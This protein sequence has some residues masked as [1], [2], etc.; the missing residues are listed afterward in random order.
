MSEAPLYFENPATAVER[1]NDL[2]AREEWGT[3]A[4][5]YDLA[6]SD[7][8]YEDVAWW[9]WFEHGGQPVADPYGRTGPH[10][11]FPE[12]ATYRGH[13]VDDRVCRVT[14]ELDPV[15]ADLL[16]GAEPRGRD[17]PELRSFYLVHHD[18]GWQL[19]DPNDERLSH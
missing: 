10:H 14:V 8:E 19:L 7:L 11:P 13:E 17:G 12:G 6:G 3:L 5:Y 15:L 18:E 2:L 4:R 9:E 16:H 1:I